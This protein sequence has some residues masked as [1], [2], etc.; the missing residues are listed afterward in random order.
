M[1]LGSI[2]LNRR[3]KGS[4][5]NATILNLPGRKIQKIPI[6]AEVKVIIF[7]DCAEV[8]LVDVIL[9]SFSNKFCLTRIRQKYCFTIAIQGHTRM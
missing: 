8:I 7:W 5:F 1:I 6:R 2:I 3:Q 9:R 4:P